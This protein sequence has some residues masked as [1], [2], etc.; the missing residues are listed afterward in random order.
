MSEPTLIPYGRRGVDVLGNTPAE[1]RPPT[2]YGRRSLKPAEWRWLVV[3][4]LFVGGMAGAAQLIAT[5]VDIIGHRRDRTLVSAARYVA[6]LGALLSPVLLTA[7]LKTPSRWYNMLRIYRH[8]SPMSIGSWTL[9][10]FGGL[11]GLTALAQVLEDVV[12]VRWARVL[13]RC[14][15]IPA[16]AAG[17]VLTTYT[18]SLLSATSTPI[19]ATGYRLLPAIFGLSSTA[20][21]TGALALILERVDASKSTRHRLERL[22]LLASLLELVLTRRLDALWKRENLNAPLEKPPLKLLHRVGV[23][24]LGILAPLAV[25]L[26]QALT[27]RDLRTA[28]TLASVAALVGGYAQRAVVVLAGKQS[29]E[30]PT[31]YFHFARS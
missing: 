26:L 1:T 12:A 11:S 17:A 31:D 13:A 7:D 14:A 2:Y 25:H 15:G 27:G 24:G 20:T 9:L 6:F 16:G 21:A 29:A 8:T 23:L 4:Y 22:A 18:G 30:R 10:A 5:V 28:S 19:W 3:S